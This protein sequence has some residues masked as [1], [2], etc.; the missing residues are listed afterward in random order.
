MQCCRI[1]FTSLINKLKFY[2]FPPSEDFGGDIQLRTEQQEFSKLKHRL[3][4]NESKI[5]QLQF[6]IKVRREQVTLEEDS[7]H[8]KVKD[9]VKFFESAGKTPTES[10]EERRGLKLRFVLFFNWFPLHPLLQNT[11]QALRPL[12]FTSQVVP[13]TQSL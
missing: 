8:P 13:Y 3:R 6:Q 4:R 1:T 2:I 11:I 10:K 9:L 12:V 7:N 5:A